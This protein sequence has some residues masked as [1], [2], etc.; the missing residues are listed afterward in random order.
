[1]KPAHIYE[2]AS[3]YFFCQKIN[4]LKYCLKFLEQ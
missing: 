3:N 2:P 4:V 1:M